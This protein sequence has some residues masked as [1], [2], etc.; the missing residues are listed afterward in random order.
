M[1]EDHFKQ[2]AWMYE[3]IW[4]QVFKGHRWEVIHV[5]SLDIYCLSV[6]L[7]ECVDHFSD[8]AECE[9]LRKFGIRH[10]MMGGHE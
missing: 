5:C 6:E 7:Q 2:L 8:L 4:V 9:D 10:V 3:P 1:L